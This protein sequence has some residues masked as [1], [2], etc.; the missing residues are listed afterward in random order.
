MLILTIPSMTLVYGKDQEI[1]IKAKSSCITD[2]NL[3]DDKSFTKIELW[4]KVTEIGHHCFEGCE[5]LTTITLP[6]TINSIGYNAFRGCD[7][8]QQVII[9]ENIDEI[10]VR[11]SSGVQMCMYPPFDGIADLLKKG[12]CMEFNPPMSWRDWN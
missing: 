7:K 6:S 11:F 2:A 3:P 9:P 12:Y 5:E 10:K 4:S 1:N 8:L